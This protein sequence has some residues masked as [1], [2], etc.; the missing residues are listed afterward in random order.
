MPLPSSLCLHQASEEISIN[1]ILSNYAVILSIILSNVVI[2]RGKFAS[3]IYVT[4]HYWS[5]VVSIQT[6]Q[7]ARVNEFKFN[8]ICQIL[9]FYS[10]IDVTIA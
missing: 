4:F 2:A 7:V 3:V 6:T 5:V 1:C 8:I 10:F 9:Y